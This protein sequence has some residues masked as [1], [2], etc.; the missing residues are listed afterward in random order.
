[1]HP[2]LSH[3]Q[4][5]D[6]RF[7]D[8]NASL[9]VMCESAVADL[10]D[11]RLALNGL[12][13]IFDCAAGMNAG[14]CQAGATARPIDLP[15][16]AMAALQAAA[17]R[18]VD[19]RILRLKAFAFSSAIAAVAGALFAYYLTNVTSEAFNIHYAIQFIALVLPSTAARLALEIRFFEKFGIAGGAAVS[20]TLPLMTMFIGVR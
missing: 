7:L 15:P 20:G 10:D 3:L 8:P 1:M 19:V 6:Q 17:L 5:V 4:N 12:S 13:A 11:V 16:D 18:N 14:L 9:V 2:S